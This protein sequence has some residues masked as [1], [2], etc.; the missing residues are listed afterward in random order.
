MFNQIIFYTPI[1]LAQYFF[2]A[3][4]FGPHIWGTNCGTIHRH[5]PSFVVHKPTRSQAIANAPQ[6]YSGRAGIL[7]YLYTYKDR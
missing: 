1:F 2:G 6:R 5:V 3:H 7:L 4:V